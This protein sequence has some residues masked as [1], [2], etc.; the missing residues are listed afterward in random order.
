MLAID[1]NLVVRY[2]TTTILNGHLDPAGKLIPSYPPER[3]QIVLAD[4]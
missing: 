3:E 4:Y 2:L 1:P